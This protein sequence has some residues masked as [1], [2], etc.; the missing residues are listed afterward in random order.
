M[1]FEL[2]E[3]IETL[4]LRVFLKSLELLG[5][6]HK[7]VKTRATGWLSSLLLASYT[8]VLREEHLKSE[9]EIAQR[10][11]ITLQ[12][13]KNILRSE[14]M[15]GNLEE[16]FKSEGKELNIHTAGGI[17]KLAY[18]LVKD[19]KDHTGLCLELSKRTAEALDIAWAK[20]LL[21]RL[22]EQDFPVTSAQPI[23]EKL[24]KVW[25]SGRSAQ[26]V[27]EELDYPIHTPIEL[28]EKIKEN[29]RMYGLE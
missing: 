10:L 29:L 25:L 21:R 15:V 12:T 28:I 19:Q 4:T 7:L 16:V 20:I 26:E 17:A 2:E 22:E 5:G 14:P 27:L 1:A 23:K 3:Q 6:T 9:Q 11:G 8:V 18:R 24:G 13:V